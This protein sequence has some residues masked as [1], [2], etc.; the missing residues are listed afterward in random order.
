MKMTVKGPRHRIVNTA[1]LCERI[2]A[3]P[4]YGNFNVFPVR[5]RSDSV[6]GKGRGHVIVN[7]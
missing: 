1:L 2:L 6:S 5:A 7:R 3:E 4:G